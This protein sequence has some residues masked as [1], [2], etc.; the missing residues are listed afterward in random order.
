MIKMKINRLLNDKRYKKFDGQVFWTYV[1]IYAIAR[2]IIE[3]FRGDYRGAQ[4]LSIF[5]PSQFI[6]LVF[7]MIALCMMGY[8]YRRSKKG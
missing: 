3:T 2:S 8:L 5:S 4:V 1:I 7:S 6:A